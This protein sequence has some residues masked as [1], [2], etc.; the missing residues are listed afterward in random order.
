MTVRDYVHLWAGE[1]DFDA[2]T[3]PM[4]ACEWLDGLK[5]TLDDALWS[6]RD[7]DIVP[8][9]HPVLVYAPSFSSVAWENADLCEYLASHGYVVIAS[10]SIGARSRG[11]TADLDGIEAQAADIAFLVGFASTFAGAD[12]S[13][14]AVAG[15]SWGGLANLFAA[16]RDDRIRALVSLDG[17]IR[18]WPGLVKSAGYVRPEQMT[19]PL[20]S[21][22]KGEWSME[23]QARYLSSAQMD[24][25]N[26][27]NAWACGD[28]LSVHMPAMT[29][30]QFSSMAQRNENVWQ[31]F[32]DP[33][34]ADRQRMGFGREHAARGYGWMARYT[35][36]FLKAYLDHEESALAF[37]GAAP[38]SNGVPPHYMEVDFRPSN[39]TPATFDFFCAEVGRRGFD[40]L[41]EIL[42]DLSKRDARFG[43]AEPALTNWSESLI[44][45]GRLDEAVALL[46]FSVRIHD[47]S[48][49]AHASL[50]RARNLAGDHAA[51]MEHFWRA[52]QQDPTNA[53]ARRRLSALAGGFVPL[54][55]SR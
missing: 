13:R 31:E 33:R 37:L 44:D 19:I 32:A 12:I 28:L 26:V 35:L 36:Q 18:Y 2:P 4:R 42:F 15:F 46:D 20:I 50:G 23:E 5:P 3:L 6:V 39:A 54:V 7:A 43:I 21:F 30:R 29:H 14:L 51:A 40:K 53:D 45:L 22:A 47:S 34:F 49:T 17:S 55:R 24:G 48:S 27:L 11:M 1:T 38:V 41:D 16:A 52:I 10:A 9:C 8:G 25:P